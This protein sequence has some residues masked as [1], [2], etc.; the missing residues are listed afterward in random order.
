MVFSD[1]IGLWTTKELDSLNSLQ[2][3]VDAIKKSG[4]YLDRKFNRVKYK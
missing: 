3:K 1:N 4:H 2:K